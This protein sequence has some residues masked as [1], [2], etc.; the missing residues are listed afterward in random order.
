M[1]SERK[2]GDKHVDGEEI[3]KYFLLIILAFHSEFTM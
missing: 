1:L 3:V 2:S